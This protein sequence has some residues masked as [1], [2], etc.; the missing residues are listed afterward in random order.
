MAG[1]VPDY[2]PSCSNCQQ[3]AL[4]SV[5]ILRVGGSGWEFTTAL[6]VPLIFASGISVNNVF[7][8][9]GGHLASHLSTIHLIIV[10]EGIS[11]MNLDEN[12]SIYE[13]DPTAEQ[14]TE[15]AEMMERRSAF[16]I[17]AVGLDSDIFQHCETGNRFTETTG[18]QTVANLSD[19]IIDKIVSIFID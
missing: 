4:D 3:W 12:Q 5:E 15:A 18:N 13:W 19:E 11:N 7:L 10:F 14:W 17:S 6:P 8:V 1:G 9:M 16:G 2:D